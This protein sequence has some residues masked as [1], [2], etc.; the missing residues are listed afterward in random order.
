MTTKTLS[1][2]S[3]LHMQPAAQC[4]KRAWLGPESPAGTA[5]HHPDNDCQ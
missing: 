5:E 4:L 1:V 3:D 2:D